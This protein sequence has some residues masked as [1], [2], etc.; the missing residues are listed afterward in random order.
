MLGCLALGLSWGCW[1]QKP[2]DPVLLELEHQSV[3]RSEFAGH[4]E[5]L[6]AQGVETLDK[7]VRRSLLQN[8]LE[9]RVLVLAARARGLLAPRA[10]EDEERQ[11]VRR[12]LEETLAGRDP[13]E[14]EISRYYS[15]HAGELRIPE[16]VTLRQILVASMN[17]ARDVRRRLL[18]DPRSFEALARKVS[19]SPEAGN[20]GYLGTFARG[21]LP[22][23]LETVAFA[24][25]PR[26]PEIAATVHGYHVLVVDAHELAH[27]T[28]LAECRE[29]IRMELRRQ[30]MEEGTRQLT[31]ELLARA[32]VNYAVL[33][34]IP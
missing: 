33:D 9:Q 17:E 7:D 18:K 22:T 4:L 19:R 2:A 23:D 3:L 29:R 14:E 12:L 11:A 15:G 26:N 30:K 6:R 25:R 1:P 34:T 16:T 8:F 5:A 28:T 10:G 32:R 24:A 27:E 13:S 20:G 21:E 31:A